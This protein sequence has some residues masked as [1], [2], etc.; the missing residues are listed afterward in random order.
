M[1]PDRSQGHPSEWQTPDIIVY[2]DRRRTTLCFL[3]GAGSS[4]LFFLF[5][6]FVLILIIVIPTFRNAGAVFTALFLL[7]LGVVGTW[8]T[9]VVA[10]LLSSGEPALVITHDGI[11]VGKVYGSVEIMLPWEEIE[12][13]YVPGNWLQK[14]LSIRST[15]VE[16][17]LSRFGPLMRFF[18]RINLMNGA[19]IAIAQ[20]FLEK[21]IE[22]IL[23]Q[24]QALYGQELDYYHIQLR[25]THFR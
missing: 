5:F 15:N 24:L 12:A 13:I 3:L 1:R 10:N 11:R 17:F 7:D 9:R 6:I 19:P 21:P 25:P 23:H 4:L 14:Q 18:L 2:P 8:S 20:S 16:R 22:E